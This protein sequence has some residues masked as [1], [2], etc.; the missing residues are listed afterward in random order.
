MSE[1]NSHLGLVSN[2]WRTQLAR[3]ESLDD[4]SAAAVRHGFR[5]IELRQGC[6]GEYESGDP[7][8][9]H[10]AD[11]LSLA[12]RFPQ[13]RFSMA[14]E[15]PFSNGR[16]SPADPVFVAGQLAAKAVAGRLSPHLRLVDLAT[17]AADLGADAIER[18]GSALAGLVRKLADIDGVLSVENARQSWSAFRSVFQSARRQLGAEG[19]RLKLCYDPVNLLLSGEAIDPVAVTASLSPDEI[20]MVHFKQRCDGR[21]SPAVCDGDVDWRAQLAA[22][23]KIGYRGLYLF[24]VASHKNLW[25]FL[26]GSHEYLRRRGLEIVSSS[27]ES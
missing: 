12:D 14:V 19:A 16:T 21:I 9:P 8:L 18:V 11:L 6:L 5:A 24:E 1:P 10:A 27:S 7:P 17:D 26:T 25:E 4:L 3:G 23:R 13:M 15:I 2:C 22:L 20:S